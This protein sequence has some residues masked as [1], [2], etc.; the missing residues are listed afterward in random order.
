MSWVLA[1]VKYVLV[2]QLISLL[3][4]TK[5]APHNIPYS[6]DHH[7]FS[8]SWQRL[9]AFSSFKDFLQESDG[10]CSNIHFELCQIVYM[11][12][13]YTVIIPVAD[14]HYKC[15]IS[16]SGVI[17]FKQVNQFMVSQLKSQHNTIW[18]FLR[19]R[20]QTA[21][22]KQHNYTLK[23]TAS[24]ANWARISLAGFIKIFP[25][26]FLAHVCT[27]HSYKLLN[28]LHQWYPSG[29]VLSIKKR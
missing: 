5:W 25:K 1:L 29:M 24:F 14:Y 7:P 19:W 23:F 13:L 16:L 12:A 4:V 17:E 9:P 6:V 2:G 20:M 22:Y 28:S 26:N 11:V 3:P 15:Y 18:K 27:P 8:L 10:N 21:T